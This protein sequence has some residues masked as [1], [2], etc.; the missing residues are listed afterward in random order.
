VEGGKE[1]KTKL[2]RLMFL[3]GILIRKS[4]GAAMLL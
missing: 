2:G 1:D 4:L 3:R